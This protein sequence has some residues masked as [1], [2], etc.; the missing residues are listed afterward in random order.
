[1]IKKRRQVKLL[2]LLWYHCLNKILNFSNDNNDNINGDGDSDSDVD[3]IDK[4]DKM[5]HDWKV[6]YERDNILYMLKSI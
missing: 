3:D 5:C 2:H 1:M 4:D 6:Y